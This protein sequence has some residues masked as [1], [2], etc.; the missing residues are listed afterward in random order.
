MNKNWI[1]LEYPMCSPSCKL[2][3]LGFSS[4]EKIVG[5]SV[6]FKWGLG[7]KGLKDLM[8]IF[9]FWRALQPTAPYTWV[10]PCGPACS[11]GESLRE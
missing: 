5:S 11:E 10:H 2:M 3:G 8:G 4:W 7:H 1:W 6:N 9:R